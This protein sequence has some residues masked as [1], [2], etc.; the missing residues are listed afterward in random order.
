MI[1][2]WPASKGEIVERRSIIGEIRSEESEGAS[3]VNTL[4]KSGNVDIS[5]ISYWINSSIAFRRCLDK[6]AQA[7]NKCLT[8]GSRKM[9]SRILAR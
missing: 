2:V 3:V 8:L 1:R 9:R 4:R 6:C 5:G 7:S